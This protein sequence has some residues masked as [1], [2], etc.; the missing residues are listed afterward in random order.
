MNQTAQMNGY[1]KPL[2][3]LPYFSTMHYLERV[4]LGW[5]LVSVTPTS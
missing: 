4:I 5:N 3:V 1:P 2:K